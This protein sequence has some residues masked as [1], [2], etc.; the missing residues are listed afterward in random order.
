MVST[1]TFQ[2]AFYWFLAVNTSLHVAASKA[3]LSVNNSLYHSDRVTI[4]ASK[5]PET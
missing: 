2:V 1:S 3:W 5:Q 4:L